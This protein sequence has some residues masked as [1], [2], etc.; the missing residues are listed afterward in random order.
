MSLKSSSQRDT[1]VCLNRDITRLVIK[2]LIIKDYLEMENDSLKASIVHLKDMNEYNGWTI[3]FLEDQIDS[4]VF[5]DS[6]QTVLLKEKKEIIIDLQDDVL[7]QKRR[8][9]LLW[10]GIAAAFVFGMLIVR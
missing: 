8:K 4:Y 5:K 7:K 3:N 2:E 10:G 9:G 1:I 6:V